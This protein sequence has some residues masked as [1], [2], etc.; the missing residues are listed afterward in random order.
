[1]VYAIDLPERPLRKDE[2]GLLLLQLISDRASAP[3][4]DIIELFPFRQYEQKALLH[5]GGLLAK[6]A[7][8]TGGFKVPV[9]F[10]LPPHTFYDN[11][12]LMKVQPFPFTARLPSI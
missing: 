10:F 8:E 7:E 12:L 5:R 3:G 1:V 9:I 2:G 11:L 6:G 4:T